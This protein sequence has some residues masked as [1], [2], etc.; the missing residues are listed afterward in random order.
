M[1]INEIYAEWLKVKRYQVKES[2]LAS[3]VI[4]WRTHLQKE[5]GELDYLDIRMSD[6]QGFVNKMISEGLSVKTVKDQAMIIKMILLW[7]QEEYSLPAIPGRRKLIYPTGAK[8]GSKGLCTLGTS[9]QKAIVDYCEKNISPDNV[10][11]MLTLSTGLR[12]GEVCGIKF[13]DFDFKEGTVTIN[14]TVMRTYSVDPSDKATKVIIS[15]PKTL[16]S[17]RT[18]PVPSRLLREIKKWAAVYSADYYLASARATPLEP[19]ILRS[20]FN[21]ICDAAGVK[22][23]K[24]HGL[25]HTFATTLLENKVDIKTTSELL[26]HS[27]VSITMDV[28][29]HPSDEHKKR[30]VKVM[31][32]LFK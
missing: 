8:T 12:I 7:A 28:Y 23:I 5:F 17:H 1:T 13:S 19:R 6:I 10:A 30:A 27:D 9:E 2:S 22:R 25:R 21:G 31:D 29:M 15:T 14:R 4:A 32:S 16:S 11:V 24:F 26:G 3:Y 20:R 18:I